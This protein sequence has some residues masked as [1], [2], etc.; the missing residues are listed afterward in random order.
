MNG[1]VEGMNEEGREI[2]NRIIVWDGVAEAS[3]PFLRRRNL[4]PN[5][6]DLSLFTVF[7][8]DCW[9]GIMLQSGSWVTK[10]LQLV[11]EGR[12]VS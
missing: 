5:I 8:I 4:M 11:I 1:E 12:K 6:P 10:R 7:H 9:M 3:E 2:V